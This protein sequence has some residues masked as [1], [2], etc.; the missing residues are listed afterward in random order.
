[1]LAS[2]VLLLLVKILLDT[3]GAAVRLSVRTTLLAS[4]ATTFV[5][6]SDDEIDALL[7]KCVNVNEGMI[8]LLFADT[9]TT[10]VED[11][12]K[13]VELATWLCISLTRVVIATVCVNVTDGNPECIEDALPMSSVILG[14]VDVGET[15]L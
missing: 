2:T 8:L 11:V 5:T 6:V 3:E 1:M 9:P 15:A 12:S 14:V 4:V 13:S 7:T 10:P